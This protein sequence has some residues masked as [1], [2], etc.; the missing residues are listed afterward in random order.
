[1]FARLLIFFL[2]TPVIELALLIQLGDLIGF[3]PTIG[4]ILVTGVTGSYLAKREGFSAWKRLQN[5]FSSGGLPGKEL[6][7]GVIILMAGALLITPGV[8]TDVLGFA[9]LIPFTRSWIRRYAMRRIK[10]AVENGTIQTRWGTF[11]APSP[12]PSSPPGTDAANG[13]DDVQWQGSGRDT[14]SYADDFDEAEGDS[15]RGT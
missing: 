7:D 14:P 13:N 4:L 2:A 6:L 11:S 5:K 3:F 15:S 12:P 1:M 10:R 9:G 8:L